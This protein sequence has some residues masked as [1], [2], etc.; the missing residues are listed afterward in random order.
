MRA[1]SPPS[2]PRRV[3]R[4]S[5]VRDQSIAP[6]G[7]S[8]I[9]YCPRNLDRNA[10]SIRPFRRSRGPRAALGGLVASDLSVALAHSALPGFVPATVFS[11]PSFL[12]AYRP[13]LTPSVAGG[14]TPQ[15]S[16]QHDSRGSLRPQVEGDRRAP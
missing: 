8:R 11:L 7:T 6:G 4:L 5:P 2:S 16:P 10:P 12:A 1:P 14:R 13:S 9:S 3:G 15:R